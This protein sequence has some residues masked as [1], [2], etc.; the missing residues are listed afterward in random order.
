MLKS[1]SIL[2]LSAIILCCIAFSNQNKL[3][4]SKQ[5]TYDE[6][7]AQE[8]AKI[9]AKEQARADQRR[10]E[11]QAYWQSQPRTTGSQNSNNNNS[12]RPRYSCMNG[13]CQG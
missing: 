13:K 10:T 3:N 6:L 8:M 12:Q 11:A 7:V 5:L 9:Q 4:V 2:F 1:Y